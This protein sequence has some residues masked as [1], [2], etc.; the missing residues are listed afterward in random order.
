M[1]LFQ[2]INIKINLEV[3]QEV[4]QEVNQKKIENENS[5]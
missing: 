2:N 5:E 3:F 1:K 4:D